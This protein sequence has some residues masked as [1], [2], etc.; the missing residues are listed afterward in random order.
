MKSPYEMIQSQESQLP[1][2]GQE[3][4]SYVLWRSALESHMEFSLSFFLKPVLFF[5][6]P[7]HWS[8]YS[9]KY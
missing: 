6:Y 4:K 2:S 9:K 7:L 3:N 8:K 1:D 5:L